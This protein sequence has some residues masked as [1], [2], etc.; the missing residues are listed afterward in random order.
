MNR[1]MAKLS[2]Y[3]SIIFLFGGLAHASDATIASNPVRSIN[4]STLNKIVGKKDFSGLAV[5]MATW[6]RPCREE[7]P[8]LT[9]LYRQYHDR[10]IGIVAFSIDREGPAEVQPLVDKLKI[11]FPVF[12]VGESAVQHYKI[13]GVPTILVYRN[14]KLLEK[15]PGSQTHKF[16]ED[17]IKSLL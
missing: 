14:G 1:S 15:I 12:W 9:E 8:V 5:A 4:I 10:G 11:P 6:C 7:L 13:F 16:I 17:K 3:F 2:I